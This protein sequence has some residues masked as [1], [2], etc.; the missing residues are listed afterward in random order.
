MSTRG[1]SITIQ[2][3][4]W[5]TVNNIGKT[6]D[7]A[8]HTLRWVKDGTSNA[9]TNSPS[10]IDSTNAK[11]EYKIIMT[12]TECTSDFCT[13][14]GV[15]S[16]T[17]I[18][19]IPKSV[20]FETFPAVRINLAQAGT[21]TTITL[22]SG[23]SAT[24]SLYNGL[25]VSIIGGTGA[26]QGGRIVTGYVGSTKVGTVTPAWTTNPDSTSVFALVPATTDVE[27]WLLT[28]VTAAAAGVPDVN[29]KNINNV[30]AS[31][32]TAIGAYIGNAT[33]AIVVN[34]SGFVTYSNSAPPTTAAIATGVW[35]DATAGDFTTAG[36]IGKSLFTSGNAPGAASGIAIVGS[37]MGTTTSTIPTAAQ[38]ATAVWQDAT[39][40]DFTATGSIGKSLFTSG[41]VPG[42]AGGIF[43]AGSNAATT[44]NIT[45]TITTVTNLTNAATVGDFTTAMKTSLNAASPV[46]DW[47]KLTNAGSVQ[48]L[49]ATTVQGIYEQVNTSDAVIIYEGLRQQSTSTYP[50]RFYMNGSYLNT[51][52]GTEHVLGYSGA[53]PDVIISGNGTGARAH[54][55]VSGAGGIAAIVIDS[56]GTG[57]SGTVTATFQGSKT[58]GSGAVLGNAVLSGGGVASVPITSAGIGYGP[59]NM[60]VI[61]NNVPC[62]SPA[63]NLQEVNIGPP[64]WASPTFTN[65]LTTGGGIHGNTTRYY[66]IT[67]TTSNVDEFNETTPSCEISYSVPAGTNTNQITLNWVAVAWAS[68]Y[69]IYEGATSGSELLLAQV[70]GGLTTSYQD[71]GSAIN[72]PM[73][74]Y[75]GTS[76]GQYAFVGSGL[77]TDLNT[78]GMVTFTAYLNTCTDVSVS[79]VPYDPFSN[80]T[81]PSANTIADTVL[82]RDW[83]A[84]VTAVGQPASYSLMNAARKLRNH[85]DTTTTPG[86]L[87]VTREDQTTP[88]YTQQIIVSASAQLITSV[89]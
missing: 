27:S 49:S 45:G 68:G 22:D 74:T 67:A 72:T 82:T 81:A 39:S 6:G 80:T 66:R 38:N 18:V 46:L 25:A 76:G 48:Y 44:V 62:G 47:S 15:S 55:L 60:Y 21:S 75:N 53:I 31:S 8:N 19:I 70:S 43:I 3:T 52:D 54:V 28:A 26:G 33:A 1:I 42:A 56:A 4:A 79:V 83:T 63:A 85:I 64:A 14:C 23:A 30:S 10:E 86:Y 17:G 59:S 89:G 87:T 57:Y 13:L 7:S 32:V 84:T 71:G 5:D 61:K 29:A 78:L 34:G 58:F 36:S 16:T 41:A 88:A 65:P 77:A 51:D 50:I 40:G 9:P 37:N 2:Y 69:N 11:G 24:N 20:S 35:Q 73:P 12:S